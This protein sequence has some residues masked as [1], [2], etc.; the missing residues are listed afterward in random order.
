M[1]T[2]RDGERSHIAQMVRV[3]LS[4]L[5]DWR[6]SLS[7]DDPLMVVRDR[8]SRP[9]LGE[10]APDRAQLREL[11]VA[12]SSAPD[13]GRLRPWRFVIVE[14]ASLGPLGDAFASA[15]AERDPDACAAELARSRAKP[16]RAPLI[17]V[18]VA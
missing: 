18:V 11:L 17:V 15:H 13:H 10:P 5:G 3:A 14:G 2:P 7:G 1:A 4:E 16:L 12:A 8:R 9:A 6:C